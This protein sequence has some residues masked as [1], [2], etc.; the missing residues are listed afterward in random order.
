MTSAAAAQMDLF[1][2][3]PA[4]AVPPK[5]IPENIPKALLDWTREERES[6]R[7]ALVGTYQEIAVPRGLHSLPGAPRVHIA[8]AEASELIVQNIRAAV[9]SGLAGVAGSAQ[10][11]AERD[12][13][14]AAWRETEA[15]RSAYGPNA[16]DDAPRFRELAVEQRKRLAWYLALIAKVERAPLHELPVD[17]AELGTKAKRARAN[18]D[19]SECAMAEAFNE[20]P[21]HW[22]VGMK[23]NGRTCDDPECDR[24]REH[25]PPRKPWANTR[26]Q[27]AG[28]G[29]RG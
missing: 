1:A 5:N 16:G 2:E 13:E 3:S 14:H 25:G 29:W 27:E 24:C 10:R 8:H 20:G 21:T 11:A 22:P 17:L 6:V 18:A 4:P 28:S 19:A 12:E 9:V 7:L 26:E 15:G 23:A